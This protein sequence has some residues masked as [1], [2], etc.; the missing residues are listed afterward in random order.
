MNI[1]DI[2]IYILRDNLVSGVA[3]NIEQEPKRLLMEHV[4]KIYIL[5]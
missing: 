2:Y 4:K 1:S 5:S 3:N